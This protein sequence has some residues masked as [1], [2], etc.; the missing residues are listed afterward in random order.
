MS[1]FVYPTVTM[2]QTVATPL[3]MDANALELLCDTLPVEDTIDFHHLYS[4]KLEL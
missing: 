3:T 4:V 2:S 1:C